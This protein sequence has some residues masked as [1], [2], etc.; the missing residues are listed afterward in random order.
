MELEKKEQKKSLKIDTRMQKMIDDLIDMGIPL[1]MAVFKQTVRSIDGTP[2]T[3]FYAPNTN[4]P[5]SKAY[6]TARMWMTPHGVLCM[7]SNKLMPAF[8]KLIPLGA[9]ADTIVLI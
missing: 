2:E 5:N 3:A 4:G 8:Y 7:Q 9:V 1:S 6:R